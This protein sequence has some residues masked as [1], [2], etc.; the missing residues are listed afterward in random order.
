MVPPPVSFVRF[1]GLVQAIACMAPCAIGFQLSGPAIAPPTGLASTNITPTGD[2][3]NDR[4][5]RNA[6]VMVFYDGAGQLYGRYIVNETV[7]NLTY[8]PKQV[9]ER[10]WVPKT[11]TENKTVTQIQN[12]PIYSYQPQLRK[13]PGWNPFAPPKLEWQY[14]LIVQYQPV[15]KQVVQPVQYQKYV[16]EEVTKIV[17]ELVTQPQMLGQFA[18]RLLT[19]APNNSFVAQNP[20]WNSG[21]SLGMMNPVQ[22][23]ALSAQANR[24]RSSLP[25]RPIDYPVS[26]GGFQPYPVRNLVAQAPAPYYLPPT[27]NPSVPIGGTVNQMANGLAP[28]SNATLAFNTVIPSVPL[29]PTIPNGPNM[30]TGYPNGQFAFNP[31]YTNTASRP[32]F[33]WPTFSSGTG[34]LFS[35][36][37]FTSN[38]SP[39]YLASNSS[40]GQPN[41]W[42]NSSSTGFGFR[43]NTSPFLP[44][45]P[46]WGIAPSTNY[47]DPLQ[48]GMPATELR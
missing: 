28:Q 8:S 35:S 30:A 44:Q 1:I 42:V 2:T 22:Q 46:N 4:F 36:S 6:P 24:A 39:S 27:P 23:A 26:Q 13:V 9:T 19:N 20:N 21:T 7:P 16:E 41:S 38:R 5:A 17:P 31:G 10:I 3:S 18:D 43:P 34:S 32:V 15:Y 12:T 14:V 33:T 48:G 47:R 25:I 37:L 40:A 45:Q 29:R 11:I